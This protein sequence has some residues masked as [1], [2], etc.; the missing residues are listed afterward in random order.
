MTDLKPLT[1][2]MASVMIEVMRQRMAV[3]TLRKALQREPTSLEIM[4]Y[5][6]ELWLCELIRWEQRRL[7]TYQKVHDSVWGE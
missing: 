1:N 6:N 5:E 2:L 3:E 4:Y 7:E